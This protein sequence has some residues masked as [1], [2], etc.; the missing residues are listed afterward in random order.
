ML[1]Q[2]S[3]D[4]P[5]SKGTTQE[6]LCK[7]LDDLPQ[8]RQFISLF[9]RDTKALLECQKILK[10]KGLSEQTW[11][12]ISEPLD[13]IPADSPVRIGFNNWSKRHLKIGKSLDMKDIG[14]PI[15]S[16]QIESLFSLGKQLGTGEIKDANRIG[17]RLPA[18]CGK[19][20]KKDAVGV[21]GSERSLRIATF[22]N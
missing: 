5:V 21:L 15:T 7:S 2:H 6:K 14:L 22:A 13:N 1:L 3:P 18:L 9:Q 11:K 8:C 20:S 12:D 4:R 10:S 19:V 16:D 17:A